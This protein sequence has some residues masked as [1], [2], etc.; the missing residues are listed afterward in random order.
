MWLIPCNLRPSV[1][2]PASECSTVD[3]KPSL[4]DGLW[5]TS[6]GKASPRLSSWT[7]WKHRPWSQLLSGAATSKTWTPPHFSGWI[8][9]SPGFPASHGLW[10][11]SSS[12]TKTSG[13]LGMS[14]SVSFARWSPSGC[15]SKTSPGLFDS[16]CPA[17][18]ETWP[19]AG[20]MRNG[21][22]SKRP[23]LGPLTSASGSL[24]LP[25]PTA[26]TYGSNA[27]G[28]NPGPKR[29]SLESMARSGM[30]PTPKASDGDKGGP[31]NS[32][33]AGGE[34]LRTAVQ[35]FPTPRSNGGGNAGGSN[36]RKAAIKA[37]TYISGQLNPT[38]V[39]W[40]MGC[41]SGL[42]ALERWVTASSGSKQPTRCTN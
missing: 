29:H 35:S 2:A 5:A 42:T 26:S 38:W 12:G 1:S 40:L 30:W 41:P 10:P 11:E 7:G 25:T 24:C 21:S 6:S 37:G 8:G 14:S 3:G 36:S 9:S 23:T 4:P 16:D 13:T 39:E 20:S 34:N 15:W 17:Y 31:G 28:Q 22:V 18:S 32:G 33:R 19:K 27:G